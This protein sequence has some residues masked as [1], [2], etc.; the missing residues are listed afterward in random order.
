[1]FRLIHTRS[2]ADIVD[3][4]KLSYAFKF[5]F[6]QISVALNG[7]L[8]IPIDGELFFQSQDSILQLLEGS[9]CLLQCGGVYSGIDFKEGGARRNDFSGFKTGMDIDHTAGNFRGNGDSV[10]CLDFSVA[11]QYD[12]DIL[13]FDDGCFDLQN[14]LRALGLG[15]R[16][17]QGG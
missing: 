10:A 16:L 17:F 4:E 13:C 3:L 7:F 14:L 8:P 15:R 1:M 6:G 9:V 2:G 12:A 5:Q 11:C